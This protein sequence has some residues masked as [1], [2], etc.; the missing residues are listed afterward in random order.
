MHVHVHVHV[1]VHLL[2]VEHPS[3]VS[4][5][6]F[7]GLDRAGKERASSSGKTQQG[8]PPI[9]M[10]LRSTKPDELDKSGSDKMPPVREQVGRVCEHVVIGERKPAGC[11]LAARV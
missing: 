3:S 1:H 11:E 5:D 9:A 2:P 10:L 8:A 6:R 4:V 7:E